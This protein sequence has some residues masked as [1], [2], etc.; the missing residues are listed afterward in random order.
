MIAIIVFCTL[1]ALF[2]LAI[3]FGSLK[4]NLEQSKDVN[5]IHVTFSDDDR[6]TENVTVTKQ[7]AKRKRGTKKR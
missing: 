6:K 2:I 7:P 1:F 5:N 4:S 3:L